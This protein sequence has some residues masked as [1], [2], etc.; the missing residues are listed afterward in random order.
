MS[1]IYHHYGPEYRAYLQINLGLGT[2]PTP[3][4]TPLTTVSVIE[5]TQ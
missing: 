1:M 3:S 5:S 2:T 4:S